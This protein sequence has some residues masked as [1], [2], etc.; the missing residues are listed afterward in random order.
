MQ[1]GSSAVIWF[2]RTTALFSIGVEVVAE[3]FRWLCYVVCSKEL[4]SNPLSV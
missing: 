1:D 4:N 2:L 3:V